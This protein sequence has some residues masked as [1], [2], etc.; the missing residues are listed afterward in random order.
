MYHKE[1]D[2][3]QLAFF[4]FRE[5][6]LAPLPVLL[7]SENLAKVGLEDNE[8]LYPTFARLNRR[9]ATHASPTI[10][11]ASRLLSFRAG[12]EIRIKV[13]VISARNPNYAVFGRTEFC[14]PS[15]HHSFASPQ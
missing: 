3:D 11:G 6:L 15:P 5:G 10:N 2:Q 12:L 9:R 14:S 7:I 13:K 1:S 4:S 8:N